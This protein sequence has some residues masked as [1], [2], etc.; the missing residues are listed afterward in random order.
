MPAR[1]T[2]DTTPQYYP[3]IAHAMPLFFEALDYYVQQL[4]FN[5]FIT[6]NQRMLRKYDSDL[7]LEVGMYCQALQITCRF[8]CGRIFLVQGYEKRLPW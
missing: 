5:S 3:D 6:A 4:Q 1:K 2:Q 8:E 7:A